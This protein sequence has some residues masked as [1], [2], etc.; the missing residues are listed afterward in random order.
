[1]R[2]SCFFSVLQIVL[3]KDIDNIA[4]E[5]GYPLLQ[6]EAH[7]VLDFTQHRRV[8]VVQ[9]RLGLGKEVQVVLASLGVKL[10]AVLTEEAGPV[11]GKLPV[12]LP[13]G[14][15]VVVGVGTGLVTALAEP[16]VLRGGAVSYTHLDVYKRQVENGL[17]PR[18]QPIELVLRGGMLTVTV[19]DDTVLMEGGASKVFEGEVEV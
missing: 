13:V 14:P 1:M 8:V 5:A 7:D 3:I 6:P 10:P 15:I 2:A 17:S 11:V 12:P 19:M 9:V 18:S 4:A 16:P